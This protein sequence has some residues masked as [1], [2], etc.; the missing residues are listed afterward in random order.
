MTRIYVDTV[1]ILNSIM[2]KFHNF[3][4]YLFLFY[5]KILKFQNISEIQGYSKTNSVLKNIN[6]TDTVNPGNTNFGLVCTSK[7]FRI[8]YE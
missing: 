2:Y 3:R 5:E 4:N 6:N 7:Y 1:I 8:N